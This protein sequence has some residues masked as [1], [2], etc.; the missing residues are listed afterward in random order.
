MQY[1]AESLQDIQTYI[2]GATSRSPQLQAWI[3][4]QGLTV[5]EF[6]TQLA[7]KSESN[8]M[9]LRYVLGDIERSVWYARSPCRSDR[10][11]RA[12]ALLLER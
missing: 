1:Q 5:E 4:E 7:N 11:V 6:V 2:R 12:L 10:V 9:Y 8:F 3:D